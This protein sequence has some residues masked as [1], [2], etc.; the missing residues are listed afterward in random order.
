MRT[1]VVDPPYPTKPLSKAVYLHSPLAK[2]VPYKTMSKKEI[3]DFPINKFADK[4]CSLFLWTTNQMLE[5]SLQLIKKWGFKFHCLITWDKIQG[6]N[7]LGFFRKSEF[8]IFAYRGKFD[9][10][11]KNEKNFPTVFTEKR[12]THSTKPFI[13][14]EMLKRITHE[15]RIDLFARK[16]HPG[17]ESW[18]DEL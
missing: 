8:V 14:Y 12:T 7:H 15:P 18:G 6:I 13:F 3:E 17:Y 16:R 4:Q 10:K 11:V 9:I 2:G 1:V 5:F